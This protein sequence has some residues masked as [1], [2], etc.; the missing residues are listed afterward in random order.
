MFNPSLQSLSQL[1][2]GS[3]ARMRRYLSRY[4]L[5]A[6][7]YPFSLLAQLALVWMG[8]APPAAGLAYV[9]VVAVTVSGFYVMVRS[10]FSQRFADPSLTAVQM[11]VAITALAFAYAINPSVRGMLLMIVALVLTYGAFTLP[12]SGCRRL[13]WFSVA[14][15]GFVM[16][17]S[18]WRSPEVFPP[19]VEGLHFLFSLEVL[20]AI[21]ILAGQLSQ[22]RA[23]MHT[24]KVELREALERIRLLATR[25]ELT[26]LPNRRH[27]QDL[28]DHEA[29]RT[30]QEKAPLCLCLID[31]DHFKLVNDKLGHAAGDEVL[32]MVA[33]YAEPL[34]RETDVL[35]RWGGEEFLLLLPDTQP[36]DAEKVVE[37]LRA[38]LSSADTWHERPELRV[39]FSGGITAH[40]EGESM[41]NTI[42]RA[43][44][45]LYEA[46]SSGRDRVL[47]AA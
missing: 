12:P 10:S 40:L 35:A 21:A 31:L 3:D 39:T 32:R 43:D 15:F 34:L 13:G 45:A 6:A 5:S 18:S 33:R 8:H 2:L 14:L 19:Q 24:Q 11:S 47:M 9:G 7:V 29:Q 25:D 16:G 46:K 41:Q 36:V 22:L 4:L 17:V 1:V 38:R 20:P 30:R 23:N 44:A 37:R 26:G 27:A 28:L 42:A